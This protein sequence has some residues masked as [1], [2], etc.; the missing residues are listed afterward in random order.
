MKKSIDI[1]QLL[2]LIKLLIL[3]ETNQTINIEINSDKIDI[4]VSYVGCPTM[5]GF[6]L[7]SYSV[8]RRSL[9]TPLDYEFL[10]KQGV[11]T[12]EEYRRTKP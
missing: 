2:E 12:D 9:E 1:N 10:W 6:F 11:I 4:K 8:T 3:D 7:D 5:G